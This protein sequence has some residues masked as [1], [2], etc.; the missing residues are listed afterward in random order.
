MNVND[1][2]LF[3]SHSIVIIIFFF[4]ALKID[5]FDNLT[6]FKNCLCFLFLFCS[7]LLKHLCLMTQ[8]WSAN[9]RLPSRIWMLDSCY[10]V[11][12][13]MIRFK[14]ACVFKWRLLTLT[15]LIAI[16]NRTFFN[17]QTD[18]SN[19]E[20]F[21]LTQKKYWNRKCVLKSILESFGEFIWIICHSKKFKG[22]KK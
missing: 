11:K 22:S 8:L 17:L 7:P 14:L 13:R 1:C 10:L 2:L 12:L 16:Q 15:A 6:S 20:N 3:A 4:F 9:G 5:H 21:F 18:V 19:S